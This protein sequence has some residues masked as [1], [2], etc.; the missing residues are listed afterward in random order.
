[1]YSRIFTGQLTP[2][3]FYLEIFPSKVDYLLGRSFPNPGGIL[4]W[5]P[6]RLTVE[7]ANYIN[8]ELLSSDV[9]G[10]APTVFWGEMYA[11]FG[12]LSI[13]ISSVV[14]G[15]ILYM[16]QYIVFKLPFNSITIG[17]NTWLIL[18][19]QKL[20]LTGLSSFLI[21]INLFVVLVLAIILIKTEMKRTS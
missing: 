11:N 20:A 14:V 19:F 21:N 2:A 5:E 9:T 13:I 7:V 3:Y 6:Y 17:L 10:T 16:F 15:V 4:P 1:I 12:F 8:P 18:E